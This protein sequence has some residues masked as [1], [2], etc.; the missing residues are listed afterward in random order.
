VLGIVI[1]TEVVT[2]ISYMDSSRLAR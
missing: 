1:S 2:V